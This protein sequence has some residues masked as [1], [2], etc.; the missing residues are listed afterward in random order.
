M[1]NLKLQSVGHN[2]G[3]PLQVKNISIKITPADHTYQNAYP[4][5]SKR[6]FKDEDACSFWFYTPDSTIWA[7]GDSRLMPEHLAMKAQ[8][9]II[10]Y[11]S[12][13]EWHFSFEGVVKIA[14][15]YPKALLLLVI[16]VR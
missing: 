10:F 12:G 8:D 15:A 9:V 7:T 5:M 16:V 14:N 3:E 1:K 2:I 6:W 4:G 11:F 13:S